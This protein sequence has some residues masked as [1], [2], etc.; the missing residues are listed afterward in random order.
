MAS[1]PTIDDLRRA[2]VAEIDAILDAAAHLPN[3]F[4]QGVSALTPEEPDS[5]EERL[6]RAGLMHPDAPMM[7]YSAV[8][9]G[10]EEPDAFGEE[11]PY[12]YDSDVEMEAA[13]AANAPDEM[14]AVGLRSERIRR[15]EPPPTRAVPV[16]QGVPLAASAQPA[17]AVRRLMYEQQ[18]S[19]AL[20]AQHP[21]ATWLPDGQKAQHY[22]KRVEELEQ[23][24]RS[25]LPL[26]EL[27]L[28]EYLSRD[29]SRNTRATCV[30]AMK[31]HTRHRPYRIP[32]VAVADVRQDMI[33]AMYAHG[34]TDSSDDG[35]NESPG[36]HGH[37][38]RGA[39]LG[40]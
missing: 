10:E 34:D 30:R 1:S 39:R 23:G 8:L 24:L 19:A 14:E 4:D 36:A 38:V 32:S 18:S 9:F 20:P 33:A 22:G 13:F 28:D 11:E 16:A 40:P 15:L 12:V 37:V 7:S 27:L 5:A 21:W 31:R 25:S 6:Q 3:P 35:E 29:E 26:T 2:E 17:K